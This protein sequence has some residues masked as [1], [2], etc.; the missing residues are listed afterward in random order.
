[1]RDKEKIVY[2][3]DD[4]DAV[5]TSLQF[6]LE[7]DDIKARSYESVEAFEKDFDPAMAGCVLADLRM[8]M[9]SGI[10]LAQR[11][12]QRGHSTPVIIMTG[13]GGKMA[14]EDARD[15]GVF[16]FLSKPF[17]GNQLFDVIDRALAA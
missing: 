14:M 1:M 6:L 15:A 12:I 13:H 4:D 7:A 3:V 17:D 10:E 9:L 2:I 5:R 16:G 8:P 11:L